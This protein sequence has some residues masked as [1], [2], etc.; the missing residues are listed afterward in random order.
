MKLMKIVILITGWIIALCTTLPVHGQNVDPTGK[1]PVSQADTSLFGKII[2]ISP[3]QLLKGRISGIRVSET[4]GNPLGAITTTIRGVNSIRGNSEPLWII[5]GTILNPSNIEVEPMFWQDDYSDK[6]YTAIQNSLASINT[7][8][9]E[10]IKVLKD[11]AGTAIYGTKGGNGVIIITTKQAKQQERRITWSSGIS[12]ASSAIGN[13]ML[14]LN[15]YMNFQQQLGNN[16]S[17][18]SNPVNWTDEALDGNLAISHNHNLVVSGIERGVKYLISG[19]YRQIEGVV[20]RNNSTLGG[21]RVNLDVNSGR[22]LSFGSRIA[23]TYSDINMTKGANPVGG[24]S[25]ITAIKSG[26][27]DRMAVNTFGAWQADYDDNS[28]EY[29]VIPSVYF[30]VKPAKD[31]E[32]KTNV[33]VDFRSK[34]RSSYLGLQTSFGKSTNGAASLSSLAAYGFNINSALSFKKTSNGHDFFSSLGLDGLGRHN[35]MQTMNG[36]DFFSQELR[37]KSINI[38]SSKAQIRKFL[39]NSELYGFFGTVSYN[40]NSKYGLNGT[41]RF[42]RTAKQED[43]YNLYPAIDGWWD[44]KKESLLE[45]TNW[46]SELKFRAGWGKAGNSNVS[47][48]EHLRRYYS[49]GGGEIDP[50]LS[51]FHKIFWKTL[52][53]E[54]NAGI[55]FGFFGDRLTLTATYYK[56][57][58]DDQ[59]V[60]N[61]FGEEFGNDGFWRYADRKTVLERTSKLVNEGVELDMKTVILKNKKLNWIFSVNGAFNKNRIEQVSEGNKTGG[62]IG[63][64]IY[65]TLNQYN[66]PV[67]SLW[68]YRETGI[69]TPQNIA[70]APTFRGVAPK[71]GD[72]MFNDFTNNGD[73]NPADKEI[74]GNPHPKFFGGLSSI[75]SYKR[76]SFDILVE[77]VYGHDILN[78][79][80]MMQENVYGSGNVT[81]EAFN[82]AYNF[83]NVPEYPSVKAKG[84]GEIS[85]RYVEKGDFTRLSLVKFGYSVPLQNIVWIKSLRLNLCINNALTFSSNTSWNPGTSSFGFDNSRLG[86]VYGAYPETRSF[87]FGVNASF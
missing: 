17:S 38:A 53:N 8:D 20:E 25:T 72:M 26:I 70:T 18:L 12:I 30:T 11:L 65:A 52:S 73:V 19:F 63:S 71:V 58:T 21:L 14:N 79:D 16:V 39:V 50:A 75:L 85:S 43:K 7:E 54:I 41:I 42:D 44:V 80:K 35:T 24:M 3:D 46:I 27:P 68:G 22:L 37:A 15:D 9:I 60:L 5:D 1:D 48:Y 31:L 59:L 33:G 47:P 56:K 40:Y 83:T 62:L 13:E 69:V 84:A 66:Q 6:D 45:N 49:G 87:T 55:D 29:R 51:A 10:S 4:D 82:K 61:S 28:S 78:L 32:F 76:F 57:N 67:S 34:D 81:K 86:I 23:L 2:A 74:I 36:I 77:G 64:G